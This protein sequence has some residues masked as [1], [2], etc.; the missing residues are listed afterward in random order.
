MPWATPTVYVKSKTALTLN[1]SWNG[2][3]QNI[4][5]DWPGQPPTKRM[6]IKPSALYIYIYPRSSFFINKPGVDI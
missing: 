1:K 3:Q 2:I 5:R 4:K 6:D